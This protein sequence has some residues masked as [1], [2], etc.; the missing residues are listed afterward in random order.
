MENLKTPKKKMKIGVVGAG[1][2]SRFFLPLFQ[3]HPDVAEVYVTDLVRERALNAQE[4]FG[5]GVMDSFE[6]MLKSDIDCIALFVQR[7]LH[8][9]LSV[10]ALEAGKNVYSAVPMGTSVEECGEIIRLVK[11]THLIYMMGETCYYFPCA[12]FCREK[13]QTGEFGKFVYGESQYYHDIAGFDFK[14][15]AGE[16]WKKE[17]GIP[18]M[19]YPTHSFSMILSSCNSY[20]KRLSA[21]G[22]R[23]SEG[24][25]IYGEGCNYWNNPFSDT[26]SLCELA[27]GGIA[28][29]SEFRRTGTFKPSSYLS[30]FYGTRG[31]YEYSN[32]QH[33]FEKKLY[34]D[35]EDVDFADVSDL[36]NPAEMTQHKNDP[37]F[38]ARVANNA[39]NWNSCAP[40]QPVQRLPQSFLPLEN[41]HYGTHKFLV[42]DFVRACAAGK[43]PPCNA[44]FAARCNIPGLI[45]QESALRGGAQME[46]P[47][48]GDAPA[49]WPLLSAEDYK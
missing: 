45:A 1:Q 34:E 35:K 46:V 28:R 3:A 16:N 18:P 33:F 29:V 39:W 14:Y 37:D 5:V 31:A 47:D 43:L 20:V 25:G 48:F 9:P 44:W 8:G 49:D 23:D 38:K 27:N 19:Y 12:C 6:D 2:F 22:Y 11:K 15:T 7:H 13:F 26:A 30:A 42:D 36:V 32:A 24:D 4:K 17:A 21:L 40:V 10:K 41:G